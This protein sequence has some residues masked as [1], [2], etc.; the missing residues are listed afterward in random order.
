MRYNLQ[1]D[2]EMKI[3]KT[4]D[5]TNIKKFFEIILSPDIFSFLINSQT[6]GSYFNLISS[7]IE[8]YLNNKKKII[9]I[10]NIQK[11]IKTIIDLIIV[12]LNDK[13]RVYKEKDLGLLNYYIILFNI[14]KYH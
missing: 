3:K 11:D 10:Q 7:M 8:K 13:N 4:N 2:K 6:D 14:L 9:N 1:E 12:C 5:N